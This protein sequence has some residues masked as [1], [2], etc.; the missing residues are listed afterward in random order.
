MLLMICHW[1]V[2]TTMASM[3]VAMDVA[4]SDGSDQNHVVV[5]MLLASV[6]TIVAV[7]SV[8][9]SSY[10]DTLLALVSANIPVVDDIIDEDVVTLL[11]DYVTRSNE[12]DL[13][14]IQFFEQSSKFNKNN[15]TDIVVFKNV[16]PNVPISASR[17]PQVPHDVAMLA[18]PHLVFNSCGKMAM[19]GNGCGHPKFLIAVKKY[20]RA[21]KPNLLGFVE[22]CISGDR[23]VSIISSLDFLTSHCIEAVSLTV[24]R[25]KALWPHLRNLASSIQGYWLLMCDFSVII[26]FLKHM[27]GADFVRPSRNFQNFIF[28]CGVQD[29]GFQG[30]EF[31]WSHGAT[32]SR[33]NRLITIIFGMILS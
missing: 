27:G 23:V 17:L 1:L 22:P 28:E 29:M 14:S 25:R 9:P 3:S 6:S 18:I 5:T 7:T 8:A 13:I 24:S 20:I 12:D 33:H 19:E 4:M 30:P 15:H 10:K 16:D 21:Y 31:T 2:S 26:G 32:F 11:N